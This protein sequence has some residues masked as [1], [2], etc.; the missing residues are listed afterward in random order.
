MALG[1]IRLK[2]DES[3]AHKAPHRIY[4]SSLRDDVVQGEHI[5]TNIK[6]PPGL[7]RI[8]ETLFG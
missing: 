8:L 2:Y 3:K 5:A 4:I 7:H 6:V 1:E